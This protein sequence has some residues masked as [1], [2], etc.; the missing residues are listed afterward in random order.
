M[1]L[2]YRL[3]FTRPF[4][5][6]PD[7]NPRSIH[8]MAMD[9]I[10]FFARGGFD[11]NCVWVGARGDGGGRNIRCAMAKDKYYFEIIRNLAERYGGK[12]TY[13]DTEYIFKNVDAREYCGPRVEV[14]PRV[15]WDIRQLAQHYGPDAP[16]AQNAF[17]HVYYGMVA[18]ENFP[19]TKLGATMK[20]NGIWNLLRGGATVEHA[21]DCCRGLGYQTIQEECVRHGIYRNCDW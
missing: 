13:N 11:E 17:M 1:N 19:G 4:Y 15:V 10:I 20:M 3:D 8:E 16:W 21:A 7:I 2:Q 9:Q 6:I 14:D 18:E 5:T 12:M